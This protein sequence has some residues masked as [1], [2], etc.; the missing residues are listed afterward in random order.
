MYIAYIS[1]LFDLSKEGKDFFKF[2]FAP[3]LMIDKTREND[4]EFIC[5]FICIFRKRGRMTLNFLCMFFLEIEF[6]HDYLQLI[7]YMHV[8]FYNWYRVYMFCLQKGRSILHLCMF[9]LSIHC[10]SL[11]LLLCMS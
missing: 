1:L 5:M 2:I 10:I 11:C 8:Y 7:S 9:V 3:L 4:F 6:I